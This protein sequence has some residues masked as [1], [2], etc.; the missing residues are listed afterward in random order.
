M[1]KVTKA[2]LC[3]L[4]AAVTL[5]LIDSRPEAYANAN[6]RQA[7][8]ELDQNAFVVKAWRS[9]GSHLTAVKGKLTLGE[10]PVVNALLQTGTRGRNIRTSQDGSFELLLD[11]SLIANTLIR[12][13]SLQG[14]TVDDKPIGS[15]EEESILSASTVINVYHPIEVMNVEPSDNEPNKVKVYARILSET[16][17]KISFFQADK[18]RISGQVGDADGN[19]IKD[20]VVWIDRER[21]EGFAKSTPTNTQ[22]KYEMY[23]WPED[24]GTNLTVMLGTR[25]Y[26]L[27]DGKVFILPRNTSV[28]ISIRLPREGSVIDDKPPMLVCTTTKGA[29]YSGLL[30]GIDVPPGTPYSLTIPDQQGRFVLTVPKDVWDKHPYFFETRLTKFVGQEKILKAG[31]ELPIDFVHPNQTDPRVNATV[32]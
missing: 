2:F 28:D 29:T 13:T 5:S 1:K 15:K 25:R 11:L 12:I 21:G 22:G 3:M 7:R 30:A 4:M 10:R 19:P 6:D 18:Y 9:D 24:E 31:D 8:I 14:A 23:Y 27:P 26:V 17:D 20:A 16:G 32:S